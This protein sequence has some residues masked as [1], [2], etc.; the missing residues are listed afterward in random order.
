MKTDTHGSN[1]EEWIGF[2]LD[3]T[4]AKYNGWK[5]I[6]NIGEPVESQVLIAKLLHWL[7]KKIKI[8]TA[9]VAPRDGKNDSA[10]AKE[11]VEEWCRKHLG[12]VP[13]VTYIK[14][15]S[16]IALFDDR[17]V[18]VEQNTGKILGGWPDALPKASEKARKAVLNIAKK[19]EKKA[20]PS[21]HERLIRV[22]MR[23]N[24]D[25]TREDAEKYLSDGSLDRYL[26]SKMSRS[27]KM[28]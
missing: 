10:K 21:M 22:V 8:L 16:M 6:D 7:G 17:A 27:P 28:I 18:S 23:R 1:D 14:D 3:G 20:A 26:S 24:P 19:V 2:D 15:A 11:Y 25:F 13:E 12:F 4:L 5:G 9:R